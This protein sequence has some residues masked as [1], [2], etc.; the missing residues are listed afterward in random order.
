MWERIVKNIDGHRV[1]KTIY[2]TIIILV[3]IVTLQ[4]H[5]PSPQGTIATVVLTG[6]GVALAEFYSEFIGISIKKQ[7][8][9]DKTERRHILK[10]VSAVMTGAWLPLPFVIL[11]WA[12]VINLNLA[13]EL[14]KWTMVGVLLFYGYVASRLSGNSHPKSFMYAIMA[15][16][17]G[18]FVVLFKN[19][20]GH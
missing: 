5:P 20:F 15:S 12:G 3:V 19:A 9:L 18:I 17:I 16:L 7:H 2:G 13:I 14:A 1:A 6:L 11:A 10:D 4:D 8:L